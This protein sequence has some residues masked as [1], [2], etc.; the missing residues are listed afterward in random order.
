MTD[1]EL[2]Q[3]ARE[4]GGVVVG[5]GNGAVPQAAN[6]ADLMELAKQYGGKPVAPPPMTALQ[7]GAALSSGVNAGVLAG[8]PGLVADTGANV[9]DLGRAAYGYAGTKLG[10][11]KPEDMPAPLNRHNV[12]GS[13]QWILD[14]FNR[15]P[16]TSAL[17][18]N[19]R[20]D[21]PAAR[22][23]NAGGNAL[24]SSMAGSPANMAM[25]FGSGALGQVAA[26]ATGDP[27]LGLLVSMLPQTTVTAAQ[28]GARGLLRG[29]EQGRR[30]LIQR[31]QDFQNAGVTPTVGLATGNRVPQA[32]EATLGRAPGAAGTIASKAADI[33]AQLQATAN[34][35]RDGLSPSYGPVAAGDA[36]RSAIPAYRDQRNAI[37]NAML[38]RGMNAV[39]PDMTFP[40]SAMLSRGQ[41]TLTNIPGAPNVSR[42]VNQ[43]LGFTQ[44]L[45]GALRQ[46]AMPQ[47][48]TVV[49]LSVLGPNGQPLT[50]TLPGAPGGLPMDALRD[51]RTRIG[52]LAYAQN[53]LLADANQGA[54]KN[55]YG[56]AKQDLYSA[57]AL[58]DAQRVA[59]GQPPVV[60]NQFQRAD[61]FYNATQDVLRKT[62]EPIY[63]AGENASEG[64][65]NRFESDAKN[66]GT[67]VV[68]T[69]ASM[70]LD[71][72]R[73]AAATVIDRLGR[74]NPGAQNVEGDAF[75]SG[76]FLTNWNKIAPQAKTA[77]TMGIPNGG[78]VRQSLDYIAKAAE[79]IK[80][81]GKVY[82]NP[83]GTAGAA[84]ALGQA[85]SLGGSAVAFM[86]GHPSLGLTGLGAVLGTQAVGRFGAYAMTS[87]TFLKWL[88]QT[89]E[90][91][92]DQIGAHLRRLAV[93]ANASNDPGLKQLSAGLSAELGQ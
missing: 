19:P 40:A 83:A 48:P 1:D 64:S 36:F 91:R 22:V 75:S 25:Q 28:A 84:A 21:V 43:P 38:D 72:R 11:L 90:L 69:M 80:D 5:P 49:P 71:V 78:Q 65:F 33:N 57:G 34:A 17:V 30:D 24:G 59:N 54:L 77:I 26:E 29:G 3:L 4:H 45:V 53:P 70:P 58:A 66:S 93:M 20:P 37:Y 51:L 46:D 52:S 85:A 56:G 73:T 61:R 41:A 82:A 10:F 35:V 47:P 87:P 62:L 88:S 6:D 16:V 13:S 7:A 14:Q 67:S 42:V 60:L 18:T 23:L 27:N 9:I 76:T 74:A 68:Q 39:P 92:A 81:A 89:S 86:T 32:I 31:T 79:R 2:L 55:L 15:T 63:R 50:R 12:V 8:I 44:D